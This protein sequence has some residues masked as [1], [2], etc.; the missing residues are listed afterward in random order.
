VWRKT[1]VAR[2][3]KPSPEPAAKSPACTVDASPGRVT[4]PTGL[5]WV[6]SAESYPVIVPPV[7]TRRSQRDADALP[8]GPGVSLT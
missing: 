6:P 8:V 4:V 5:Q 2:V 1:P 3:P 7:R